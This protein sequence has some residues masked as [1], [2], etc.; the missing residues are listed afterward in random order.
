[1]LSL[2]LTE[3]NLP[4]TGILGLR[5][6]LRMSTL[7]R[8]LMKVLVLM[9]ASTETTTYSLL[10]SREWSATRRKRFYTKNALN[11][12]EMREHYRQSLKELKT[13]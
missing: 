7:Y 13:K 1:M 2:N 9:E 5:R 10:P 3:S 8:I 11:L 4:S 12:A 6:Q